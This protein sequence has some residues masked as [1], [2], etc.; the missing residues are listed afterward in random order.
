MAIFNGIISYYEEELN[1]I[2]RVYKKLSLSKKVR[3]ILDRILLLH[4]SD[5][6]EGEK[7]IDRLGQKG[8]SLALGFALL[9]QREDKFIKYGEKLFPEAVPLVHELMEATKKFYKEFKFPTL[10]SK[11]PILKSGPIL[12]S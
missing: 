1:E 11:F 5:V 8:D 12:I 2:E 6:G 3:S 10:E 7:I 4:P 9:F